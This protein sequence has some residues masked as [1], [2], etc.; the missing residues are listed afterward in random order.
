MIRIAVDGMGGDAAPEVVV[1]GAVQAANEY[2]Y[3]IV[4]V[5]PE[6]VL[7]QHLRQH[8]VVGGKL[9]IHHA[10][11]IV[12]M[13]ESPVHA[14]KRKRDSSISVGIKLVKEKKADAFVSAGNTGAVVAA[15]TLHLGLLKGA[16]RPGIAITAPT[17]RGLIIIIDV[18]ANVDSRAEHLFQY[19]VMAST[20]VSYMFKKPRPSVGLLNIGEEESKGT[21]V[22]RETYKMLRDSQ[23]NFIGNIEGRDVFNGRSDVVVCDGFVGNIVLKVTESLADVLVKLA[24]KEFKK[25]PLLRFGVWLFG[26][27]FESVQ[28]E[29]DYTEAGGAQLLGVDGA[30]VIS[31][32]SSNAKAIKNAI[33]VAAQAVQNDINEHLVEGLAENAKLITP[34]SPDKIPS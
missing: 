11:E 30:V 28:K 19:A 16:K 32:G 4:L 29:T 15:A 21:D 27:F 10:S 26:P 9:T 14:V 1:A 8:H 2:D 31:H 13:A 12:G 24:V 6:D 17:L 18:G 33:K 25:N 3:E 7:K 20:Y 34:E 23:L 22:M 5:G